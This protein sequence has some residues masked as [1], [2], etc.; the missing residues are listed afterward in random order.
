MSWMNAK[1]ERET[2][3]TKM[4]ELRKTLQETLDSLEEDAEEIQAAI[5]EKDIAIAEMQDESNSMRR[6]LAAKNSD[7]SKI[8]RSLILVSGK[9]RR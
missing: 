5:T 3:V 8:E 6:S 4:K 9:N 7:I 1:E 2:E